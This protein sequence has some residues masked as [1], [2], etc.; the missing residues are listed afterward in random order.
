MEPLTA[1][2]PAVSLVMPVYNGLP[3]V[4]ETVSS[5]LSQAYSNFSVFIVDNGS[6]DGTADW[7]KSVNDPRVEVVYRRNT[8][9]AAA[10]WSQATEL[11][12]GVFTK[13]VC[14]D[15]LLEP[16][17]LAAQVSAMLSE[18]AVVMAA[19]RRNVINTDGRIL[20]RN[21]GLAGLNGVVTGTHAVRACLRAGTNLLGE[22]V[23]VLFKTSS[24]KAAMPWGG[25][26][27][28]LTDLAT[29]SRVILGEK[30]LCLPE[31]VGSFRVSRVSWTSRIQHQQ[32]KDF[33]Q[34]REEV[35]SKNRIPWTRQ[36]AWLSSLN[37]RV[38]TH[39]RHWYLRRA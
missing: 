36:D 16:N 9:P 2:Q 35:L 27:G 5:L 7:L 23:S 20:K 15:D 38:R 26:S 30:V 3:F 8:Q 21:Y 37:L 39:A 6:T 22:P 18:P 13:L 28:Y 11:A 29:Y 25:S 10:N 32:E 4:V 17:S 31:T 24:L 1:S 33:R 12:T 19:S 14:A 34:W